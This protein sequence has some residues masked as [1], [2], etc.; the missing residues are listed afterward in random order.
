MS[1]TKTIEAWA[2]FNK[3]GGF[4]WFTIRPT[5]LASLDIFST[6]WLGSAEIK[7]PLGYTVKRITISWEK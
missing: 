2:V 7:L 5:R 6:D 1:E 4:H 3:R